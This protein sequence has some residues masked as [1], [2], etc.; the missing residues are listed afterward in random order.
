[1]PQP[2][3]D[4]AALARHLGVARSFVYDHADRLGAIRL[5]DGPRPRLRFDVDE[6]RR[7]LAACCRSWCSPN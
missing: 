2:L 4:A 5:G 6:A 7:R 1:M 3:V